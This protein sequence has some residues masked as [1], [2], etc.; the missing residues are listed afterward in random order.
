VWTFGPNGETLLNG[1]YQQGRAEEY[2]YT[3]ST[4]VLVARAG[5]NYYEYDP[6]L[7]TLWKFGNNPL[8]GDPVPTAPPTAV[9]PA[10]ESP[11]ASPDGTVVDTPWTPVTMFSGRTFLMSDR[12]G[13]KDS[14]VHYIGYECG[15]VFDAI[16]PG[17]AE[18]IPWTPATDDGITLPPRWVPLDAQYQPIADDRPAFK[19]ALIAGESY[20]YCFKILKLG[21]WM[22]QFAGNGHWYRG[23]GQAVFN[24]I[25]D[26]P[27]A[28]QAPPVALPTTLTVGDRAMLGGYRLP[29]GQNS[30]LT[31]PGTGAGVI[32]ADFATKRLWVTQG[33]GASDVAE[34]LLPEMGEGTDPSKWPL[35]EPV[36]IIKNWFQPVMVARLQAEM[37]P[38]TRRWKPCGQTSRTR[39]SRS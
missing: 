7:Q 28:P 36:R 33:S 10:I 23:T 21:P 25:V 34:F 31:N 19:Y 6:S 24:Q 12:K 22:F 35:L 38:S 27:L 4:G 13:S 1:V 30:N 16:K 26:D 17:I 18:Q 15:E 39:T 32:A 2:L 5:T 29:F 9:D 8:P 11:N 14:G 3:R 37:A 20:G